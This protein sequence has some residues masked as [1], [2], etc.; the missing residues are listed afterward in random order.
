MKESK[1]LLISLAIFLFLTL[2]ANLYQA[3]YNYTSKK[4]TK[5]ITR[6]MTLTYE[7]IQELDKLEIKILKYQYKNLSKNNLI[8]I[9]SKLDNLE[10]LTNDNPLQTKRITKIREI[11]N[12]QTID[13]H[14]INFEINKLRKVEKK[15]INLRKNQL[16]IN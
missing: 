16:Q 11:L 7:V 3:S 2:L 5:K 9:T 1:T 14:K 12:K 4:D 13:F 6:F 10:K 15:I 8:Q